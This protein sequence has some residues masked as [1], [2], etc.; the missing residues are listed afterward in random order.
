MARRLQAACLSSGK[1]KPPK[2]YMG[3]AASNGELASKASTLPACAAS[4]PSVRCAQVCVFNDA[5]IVALA[6]ASGARVVFSNDGNLHKDIRNAT[7]VAKPTGGI[8]QAPEHQHLLGNDSVPGRASAKSALLGSIHALDCSSSTEFRKFTSIDAWAGLKI[9]VSVVQF[10]PW[11]PTLQALAFTPAQL[12]P[13]CGDQVSREIPASILQ[14][15][16]AALELLA[17]NLTI[18]GVADWRQTIEA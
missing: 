6:R 1:S 17:V 5:H 8:Y 7:L 14:L 10:R 3:G 4:A 9:L 12:W 18:G 2:Q 11:P 13:S 15:A 16:S